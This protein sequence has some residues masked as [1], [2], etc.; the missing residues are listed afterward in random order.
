MSDYHRP[1]GDQGPRE[2]P[3]PYRGT[4]GQGPNFVPGSGPTPSSGG[5]P[6]QDLLPQAVQHGT[7][8][9]PVYI[10][11]AA[12]LALIVIAGSAFFLLRDKGEDN[13]AEYC[14]ELKD[15]T[16]DGDLA[17]AVYG[18]DQST[19]D[20]LLNIKNIAPSSV[21]DD[22]AKVTDVLQGAMD[23]KAPDFGKAVQAYNAL[24]VIANDSKSNCGLTLDIPGP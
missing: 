20:R 17:S 4:Y 24:K 23:N 19:I 15:L 3:A 2:G 11:V 21:A 5:Y 12:V 7:N 6:R 13:R 8:R 10:G 18:A 22:W 16:Q 9:T 14:A 1:P